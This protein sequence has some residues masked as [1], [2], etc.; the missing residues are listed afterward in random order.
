M[1]SQSLVVLGAALCVAAAPMYQ[2][3]PQA[4]QPMGIQ[5]FPTK[6]RVTRRE[7]IEGKVHFCLI[8]SRMPHFLSQLA[9]IKIPIDAM[10]T[11]L[12]KIKDIYPFEEPQ[13]KN[14]GFAEGIC[15]L[16][17]LT[18]VMFVFAS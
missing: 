11:E 4:G 14:G 10:N 3:L 18:L 13:L 9:D 16:F 12:F 15:W 2:V 6:S 5:S 17:P 8:Q 1:Q 7:D